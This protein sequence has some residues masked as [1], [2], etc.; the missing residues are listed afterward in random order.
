MM[1][2]NISSLAVPVVY[3]RLKRIDMD[4]RFTYTKIIAL[5]IDKD[6][7]V[8]LYPNPVSDV[9]NLT[10][11]LNKHQQVQARIV[12]NSGKVMIQNTWKLHSAVLYLPLM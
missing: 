12:D 8:T 11:S 4:S 5:N 7:I 6:I 9:A 2:K 10:I 3:Y 1:D